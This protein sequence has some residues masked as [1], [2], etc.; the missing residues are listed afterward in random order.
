[1][2]DGGAAFPRPRDTDTGAF[3]PGSEGMS[4]RVWLAGQALAGLCANPET[5]QHAAYRQV[6][7][8]AVAFADVTLARLMPTEQAS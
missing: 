3:D 2:N 1:M 8:D 5:N 6:A 7:D 4:V